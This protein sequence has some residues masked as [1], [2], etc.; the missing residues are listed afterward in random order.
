MPNTSG[1]RR[2]RIMLINKS[3]KSISNERSSDLYPAKEDQKKK[4]AGVITNA[5]KEEKAVS[6]TES[7]TLPRDKSVKK[8]DTFPP[9]QAATRIIPSAIPGEG[10]SISIKR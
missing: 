3:I 4:F 1:N 5:S 10:V 9:G 8:F 2:M 7:A 6:V